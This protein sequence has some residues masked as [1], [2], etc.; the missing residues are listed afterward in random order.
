MQSNAKQSN[1]KQCKAKQSKAMQSKLKQCKAKQCKAMQSKAMRSKPRQC[2]ARQ[3]KQKSSHVT[4]CPRRAVQSKA[5]PR[6]ASHTKQTRTATCN[7][8]PIHS[9]EACNSTQLQ[10]QQTSLDITA[11]PISPQPDAKGSQALQSKRS[12]MSHQTETATCDI[13]YSGPSRAIQYNANQCNIKFSKA[14]P[15]L[16]TAVSIGSKHNVLVDGHRPL[17]TSAGKYG[18]GSTTCDGKRLMQNHV[19]T[20]LSSLRMKS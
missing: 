8:L 1:A 7:A 17:S 3:S 18:M 15:S 4:I 19:I 16:H 9:R 2:K 12:R 20:G 6:Q 10:Y 11:F 14:I 13:S 5:L